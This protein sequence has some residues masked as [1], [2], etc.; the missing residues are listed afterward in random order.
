MTP[1]SSNSI[2]F[3]N[4]LGL[5]NKIDNINA[6]L[7]STTFSGSIVENRP[8]PTCVCNKDCAPI[9]LE[10]KYGTCKYNKNDKIKVRNFNYADE[11][12]KFNSGSHNTYIFKNF[13][14]MVLKTIS[15]K[16]SAESVSTNVI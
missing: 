15:V 8:M 14:G 6:C 2:L 4:V 7:I 13:L 9:G 10:Y 1:Y 12:F 16:F 5:A 3:W 11:I